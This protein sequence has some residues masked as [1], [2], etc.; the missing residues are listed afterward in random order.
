MLPRERKYFSTG[1]AVFEDRIP[2]LVLIPHSQIE[3]LYFTFFGLL[4]YAADLATWITGGETTP[5]EAVDIFTRVWE[6]AR[7]M[8]FLIGM[9]SDFAAPIPDGEGWLQ[10]DGSQYLISDF[11][12]LS[13]AI[14]ST[15][16]SGS[17]PVGYFSVPD[18]RGRVRATI[19][20]GLTRLPSWADDPGGDGGESEHTLTTTEIPSHTHTDVGHTHVESVAGPNATTIGPGAP[21]PT[22]VPAIGVTG[23]GNASL[24][25]TGGD[26]AHNNVQPTIALY[27]YILAKF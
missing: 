11:P 27:T 16:N 19:N 9:I 12:E 17:E 23:T 6:E 20:S 18:T 13:E 25:N 24:T 21:Q 26:G 1:D 10:C 22:A 8:L 15:Y 2:V 3:W 5:E 4:G 7:P 14:G